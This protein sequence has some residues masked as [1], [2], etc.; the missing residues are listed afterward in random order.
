MTK[1]GGAIKNGVVWVCVLVLG[2][3]GGFSLR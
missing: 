2:E 3:S 1:I